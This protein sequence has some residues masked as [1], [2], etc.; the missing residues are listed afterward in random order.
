MKKI[1]Y[2]FGAFAALVLSVSTLSS[3]QSKDMFDADFAMK[4]ATQKYTDA[5]VQKYGAVD[6]NQS[7]DFCSVYEDIT[8]VT[9]GD[10]DFS[11]SRIKL[12]PGFWGFMNQKQ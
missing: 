12:I 7:W 5:F 3:C 9:R 10:Y 11:V 6:P 2:S 8:P 4:E 1:V